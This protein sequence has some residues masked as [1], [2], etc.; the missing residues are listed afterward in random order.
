MEVLDVDDEDLVQEVQPKKGPQGK[1]KQVHQE[2]DFE[3]E[4]LENKSKKKNVSNEVTR[5]KNERPK[6]EPESKPGTD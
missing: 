1:T 2:S 3:T 6:K 4:V 5:E